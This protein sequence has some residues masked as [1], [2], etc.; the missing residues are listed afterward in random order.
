M[1]LGMKQLEVI[2]EESDIFLKLIIRM[3]LISKSYRNV[4]KL[5]ITVMDLK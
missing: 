2:I 1:F 5:P 4:N 3:G